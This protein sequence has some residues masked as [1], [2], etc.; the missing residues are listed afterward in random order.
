MRD[1]EG[2]DSRERRPKNQWSIDSWSALQ[3]AATLL[4]MAVSGL[5]WGLKLE[6]RIDLIGSMHRSDVD[7]LT[8]KVIYLE[9]LTQRGILP[10]AEA[11]LHAMEAVLNTMRQDI[12]ACMGRKK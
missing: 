2:W 11:R 3:S 5:I 6:S 12:D 9:S 10:V 4:M 7:K 1:E 8:D